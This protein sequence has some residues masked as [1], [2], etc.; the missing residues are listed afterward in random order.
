MSQDSNSLAFFF[1]H[2]SLAALSQADRMSRSIDT[3]QFSKAVDMKSSRFHDADIGMQRTHLEIA[4][5][6]VEA[7]SNREG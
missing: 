1:S 7:E 5:V 2:W 3:C 6:V 4:D